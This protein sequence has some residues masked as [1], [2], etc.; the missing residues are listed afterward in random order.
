MN[1]IIQTEKTATKLGHVAATRKRS[2]QWCLNPTPNNTNIMLMRAKYVPS[3]W[4]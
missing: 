3:I 1:D 2:H 4:P